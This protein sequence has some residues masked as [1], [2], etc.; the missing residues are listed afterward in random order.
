MK[1][2]QVRF[3]NSVRLG[4]GKEGTFFDELKDQLDITLEDKLYIRIKEKRFPQ[5]TMSSVMNAIYWIEA[6]QETAPEVENAG[7]ASAAK[8]KVVKLN[9]G[10]SAS[11]S[12][13]ASK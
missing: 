1:I 13:E 8:R 10:T 4:S 2:K 12:S 7:A 3:G 5:E 9:P 6:P 11:G